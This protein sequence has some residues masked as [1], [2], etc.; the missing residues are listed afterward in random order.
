MFA[1]SCACWGIQA[2]ASC[3][4]RAQFKSAELPILDQGLTQIWRGSAGAQ[5]QRDPER[6]TTCIG[7]HRAKEAQGLGPI[8]VRRQVQAQWMQ[9]PAQGDRDDDPADPARRAR[10]AEIKEQEY[11]QRDVFRRVS[12]RTN[13]LVERPGRIAP[14]AYTGPRSH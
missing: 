8:Q 2:G 3:R 5:E 12:V 4:D 13:T 11:E 14:R 9:Q 7:A 10:V 6:Q 1:I